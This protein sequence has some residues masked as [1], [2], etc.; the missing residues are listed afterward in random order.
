MSGESKIQ[1]IS[2]LMWTV[3]EEPDAVANG[4]Q[5]INMNC[6]PCCCAACCCSI[7]SII[8]K[9]ICN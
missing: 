9:W 7:P 6:G 4:G 8:T 5:T 2:D 1:S 3:E